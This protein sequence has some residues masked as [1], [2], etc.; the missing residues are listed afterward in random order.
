MDIKSKFIY[1]TDPKAACDIVNDAFNQR[2]L[3]FVNDSK[4]GLYYWFNY[5]SDLWG[6]MLPHVF[7]VIY[8]L[9]KKEEGK[10]H[11]N[12]WFEGMKELPAMRIRI[13][14]ASEARSIFGGGIIGSDTILVD[15]YKGVDMSDYDQK[16]EEWKKKS[17]E[18][19]DFMFIDSRPIFGQNLYSAVYT[20]EGIEKTES[21][22]YEKINDFSILD[23]LVQINENWDV[24]SSILKDK[25]L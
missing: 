2:G 9:V 1:F 5:Y 6:R 14:P 11:P 10:T 4:Y 22:L 3:K 8:T 7:E 21:T 17:D 24:C 23:K 13:A 20:G 12:K 19:Q 18:A 16:V 15:F 25:V